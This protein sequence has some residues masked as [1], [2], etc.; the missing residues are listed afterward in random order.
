MWSFLGIFLL[1]DIIQS[2]QLNINSLRP[3]FLQHVLLAVLAVLP[4]TKYLKELTDYQTN[5]Y[6]ATVIQC[7]EV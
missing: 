7:K 5:L 1:S 2:Q 3:E 6:V 4:L